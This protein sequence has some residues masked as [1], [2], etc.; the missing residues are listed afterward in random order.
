LYGL[1]YKDRLEKAGFNVVVDDYVNQLSPE[2][3]ER[4]RLPAGEM[5]YVCRK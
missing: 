1:D 2:E 4:Y 5:L 3:V